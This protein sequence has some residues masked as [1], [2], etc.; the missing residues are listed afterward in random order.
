MPANRDHTFNDRFLTV[1]TCFIGNAMAIHFEDIVMTIYHRMG[2]TQE[3]R[4]WKTVLGYTWVTCWIWITCCWGATSYL[5][6][7]MTG[8]NDVPF[9]FAE[10]MVGWAHE[11]LGPFL[12][13]SGFKGLKT[14]MLLQNVS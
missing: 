6:M 7:G 13:S 11:N 10:R 2:G 4:L 8:V 3:K 12:A 14:M 1:F 9:P 5:K